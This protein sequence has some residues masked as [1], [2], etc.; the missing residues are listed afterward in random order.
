VINLAIVIVN[1]RTPDLSI[2]CIDALA[3]ERAGGEPFDVMLVDGGSG[4]GSAEKLQAHFGAASDRDWVTVLPLDF[5]G[6]FGWANNQ[7]MLRLLQRDQPPEFIHLL[8]PDAIVEPGAITALLD[9]IRARPKAGAVGSQL[10]EPDGEKAGS[11]FRFPSAGRELVAGSRLG[12][13]GDLFKVESV[14]IWS[15]TPCRA[16]WVTGASVMFRSAAL[17]ETGLFDD[18]FFLYFEEVELM[19]RMTRAGWEMWYVP[20]SRVM[21]IAGAATGVASG[22]TVA[23]RPHPPYR[24][25][26]RRRCL[27]RTLGLGGALFANGAWLAGRLVALGLSPI[28]KAAP[29]AIPEDFSRTLRYSFWPSARDFRPSIPQWDEPPGRRPAWSVK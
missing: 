14:V 5:N 23:V 28:R 21:H 11:A 29:G 3:R 22:G 4:D 25:E 9:E 7:A 1:Y 27:V 2:Q 26:A 12:K 19:H 20:A 24:Y 13:L 18:G 10:L 15:D 8:N 6:G 16:E 17:R